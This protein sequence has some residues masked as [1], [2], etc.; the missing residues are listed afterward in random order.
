[1]GL[2]VVSGSKMMLFIC[3]FL[4]TQV[5]GA[6][7]TNRLGVVGVQEIFFVALM[8]FGGLYLIRKDRALLSESAIFAIP[9]VM[10]LLSALLA[11]FH[12]DQPLVYGIV[13]FRR[14]LAILVFFPLIHGF[15][16]GYITKDEIIKWF[17]AIAII[18]GVLN[19]LMGG[20]GQITLSQDSFER[21][22]IGQHF[23]A[24]GGILFLSD[25][26]SKR[27]KSALASYFF[28]L[29]VLL[30]VIQTRQI[31]I[32]TLIASLFLMEIR[33]KST[34]FLLGLVVIFLIS[35][36]FESVSSEFA[37]RVPRVMELIS[38]RNE[39]SDSARGNAARA[40]F[41]VFRDSGWALGYGGLYVSWH[42]GF[43]YYFG[44]NF[45]LADIGLLGSIF[46]FGLI[47][48]FIFG[49][50]LYI[51]VK[52]ISSMSDIIMKKICV[53]IFIQL[54]VMSPTASILD[55][56]GHIAGVLLALSCSLRKRDD[57]DGR[58]LKA[59]AST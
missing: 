12:Y 13:E 2:K 42:D 52:Y 51:Q 44:P 48:V 34:V 32:A 53:A 3:L 9:F 37:S 27:A 17:K 56:R 16:V 19:I 50:Y 15:K 29:L 25:W 59:V 28:L 36:S 54:L 8:A 43:K 47:Y 7:G 6:Y 33:G 14:V 35:L 26:V 24:L 57:F 30:L 22:G 39:L 11:K 18:L 55:Y 1:M 46:R 23:V 49:G 4:N 41:Q 20:G 10:L 31:V 40:I 58:N 21:V 5:F 45:I 38:S